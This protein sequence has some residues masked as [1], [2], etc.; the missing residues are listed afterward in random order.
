MI[1]QMNRITYLDNAATTRPYDSVL[2]VLDYAM[3]EYWG[4]P[5]SRHVV[6]Q[7]AQEQLEQARE[8]VAN[9][10]GAKP[11]EVHF[12]SGATESNNIAIEGVGSMW[13]RRAQE[14]GGRPGC[15]ITSELEHPAVTKPMRSLRRD[16]WNVRYIAARHGNFDLPNLEKVLRETPD[17]RLMSIMAVQNEFG[18]IFPTEEIAR[19]RRQY[20]PDAVFHVDAVQAFGK[21]PTN[22][23]E[24]DCDM[25]TFC[26][27]KIGGP[28][29]VGAL[30]VREGVE[31]FTTAL[32]G[33]QER[34][35]RSGTQALPQILGFAEA[36][37]IISAGR[38]QAFALATSLRQRV[39]DAVTTTRPD[40]VVNSR[41]DGSPFIVSISIPGT[42]NAHVIETLSQQGICISGASACSS[43]HSLIILSSITSSK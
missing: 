23:R 43:N 10:I 33:G 29:G 17:V 4:N 19:L 2:D 12:T 16:G 38:D 35:L 8:T 37:R 13:R 28:K 15:A 42:H 5:S 7:Q 21:I 25:L 9:A 36:V 3:R 14:N 31:L 41:E 40:T 34:G 1:D 24:W 11:Q 30:Y 18:F 22:V 27:H 20:A 39:L 32:G 26:S 6:G